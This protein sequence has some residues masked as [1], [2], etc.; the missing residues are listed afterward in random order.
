MQ[1]T[2]NGQSGTATQ[3]ITVQQ[4]AYL[5][6]VTGSS[7]LNSEASCTTN[8]G[9]NGCGTGRFLVYQVLDESGNPMSIQGMQLWDHIVTA[10][11][12]S[13]SLSTYNTTCTAYGLPQGGPCGQ[14][15]NNYGQ[16]NENLAICSTVCKN[17][18]FCTTGCSTTAQQTWNINGFSL[19]ADINNVTYYC[20]NI[21]V[22]GK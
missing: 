6:I 3:S 14:I 16:F 1:Y 22:N 2:L 5:S 7:V 12:N 11:T 4:P 10:S 20:N 17:G 8:D 21:T 15:T 18:P 19:T 9:L 13:C